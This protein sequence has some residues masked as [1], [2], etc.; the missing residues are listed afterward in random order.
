MPGKRRRNRSAARPY[1]LALLIL[2]S[3]T[4][5][6]A[7]SAEIASDDP[8][9]TDSRPRQHL[10]GDWGG[11]RTSIASKEVTFDVFYVADLQANPVGGLEQTQVGWGRICGTI[12]IDFGKLADWNGLTLHATGL[13]QF[14][15][16]LGADIGVIANPSGLS[17]RIPHASDASAFDRFSSTAATTPSPSRIR[18]NVPTNSPRIGD[19]I[20]LLQ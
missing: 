9:D 15:G 7:Q 1:G 5:V 11:E 2:C 14:G 8:S 6:F 19:V 20:F 10:F 16:N 3:A 4:G 12:D 18:I 13:W 17:A